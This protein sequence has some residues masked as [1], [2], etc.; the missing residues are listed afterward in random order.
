MSDCKGTYSTVQKLYRNY[1]EFA[2][3]VT[4][5]LVSAFMKDPEAG[6]AAVKAAGKVEEAINRAHDFWNENIANNGPLSIGPRKMEFENRYR[7]TILSIG[8]RCFISTTPCSFAAGRIRISER[9]GVGKTDIKVCLIGADE[10]HQQVAEFTLNESR[11]EKND[12]T[13]I[14][15]QVI[16]STLGKIVVVHFKGYSI[17]NKLSYTLEFGEA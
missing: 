1:G 15:N 14:M 12:E 6:V 17:T 5:E 13:Q 9:D 2:K 8:E 10:S 3:T 16:R 7:G 11:A 4:G